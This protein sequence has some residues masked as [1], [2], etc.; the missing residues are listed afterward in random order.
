VSLRSWKR[1][2]MHLHAVQGAPG[3]FWYASS[4]VP[5]QPV[6][7]N[8]CSRCRPPAR[9]TRGGCRGTGPRAP[10]GAGLGF[11]LAPQPPHGSKTERR[12][13]SAHPGS[14]FSLPR[15]PSS[16][17]AAPHCTRL[18]LLTGLK[19]WEVVGLSFPLAPLMMFG[20]LGVASPAQAQ[21]AVRPSP[22]LVPLL[23]PKRV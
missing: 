8:L 15:A 20:A 12:Q 7:W 16:P 13:P 5:G 6:L 10:L 2:P 4:T 17:R 11:Q 23:Q 19:L 22:S 18:I 21:R 3:V 9:E 14:L 1:M